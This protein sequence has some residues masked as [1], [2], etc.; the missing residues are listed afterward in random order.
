MIATSILFVIMFMWASECV[1]GRGVRQGRVGTLW[2]EGQFVSRWF[3]KGLGG[4]PRLNVDTEMHLFIN[5]HT[6]RY[7]QIQTCVYVCKFG[8]SIAAHT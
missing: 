2:N 1:P 3:V 5:L 6:H 8:Y 4:K 7:I